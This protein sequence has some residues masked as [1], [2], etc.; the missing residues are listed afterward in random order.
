MQSWIKDLLSKQNLLHL[1][2]VG[3]FML[4]AL[5]FYYPLLG[6]KK[7][8][9]SDIQQYDGMS[10][11]LKESRQ[12]EDREIYWIDNAFVGMPTY[13]LGAQYP[14][15]VLTPLYKIIRILPRPAHILFLYLLASYCFLL[16][17]KVPWHTSLFG[18]IGFGFSTY[19]LIILQV[20]HNTKALAV[21]Y[22]PLVFSGIVLLY[23]NPKPFAFILTVLALALQIRANHYQMTYYMLL[24]ILVFVASIA[25][26]H[27]QKKT[28]KQFFIP[29]LWL[30][31]AGIFSLGLNA[32]PLLA[33]AEYAKF[34]TRG[35][36]ELKLTADGR[37][38]TEISTGLAYDYITEYSYGIFESFNIIAPRIQGGGSRE[39]IGED[40]ELYTFLLQQGVPPGQ[41][42]QIVTNIPTYWGSQP[43]LE[44]P[45][46][47]GITIFFFAIL[48]IILVRG[49]TRNALLIGALLSL[50]LSWGKN[51]PLLTDF[52]IDYFPFYNKFRA[53]SSIQVILEF[54]L[55][56]LAALGMN[57]LFSFPKEKWKKLLKIFMYPMAILVLLLLIKGS[58]S[59]QGLNDSYYREIFGTSIFEMIIDAR[60]DF[61]S[62]DVL[63]ALIYSLV[64]SVI[65]LAFVLKKIKPVVFLSLS[66][67]IVLV[68]LLSISER[69]IDR[70]LFVSQN[71][72][73]IGFQKT[74][75]DQAI[76]QD[77]TRYRVMEPQLGLTGARTANFHNSIGGYHGAKPRRLEELYNFYNENQLRHILDLL[78]IKYFLFQDSLG[79]RPSQNG[80]AIG[81]VWLVDSLNVVP[82][83]D[84][85]L[86][87]MKTLAV[88]KTAIIEQKDIKTKMPKV[89]ISDSLD[90]ISLLSAKIDRLSYAVNLSSERLAIFSEMY[91]PMGWQLE[92]DGK[93]QDIL[94]VNYILR[95]ALLPAG[96]Y[97]IDFSFEP[98]VVQR[99]TLLRGTTLILFVVLLFSWIWK[100]RRKV[101]HDR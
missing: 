17:L 77:T 45:A 63:R 84:A 13:Q 39:D 70:D 76:L 43:I 19:L 59:F 49:P 29:T 7:L 31:L 97:R 83:A 27:F 11:Q 72:Q 60:K 96:K 15:D 40:S 30:V 26:D 44:A 88:D 34:S 71:A 86:Q 53:V 4:I 16:V 79:L 92:I 51:L 62:A 24:L 80:S 61:Y 57:A 89:F 2:V 22:I 66:I 73:T 25:W 99:G 36:S 56:V 64:L 95:G 10:R 12:I 20:G 87:A 101:V 5:L 58:F 50:F 55:P 69:Y 85:A 47:I 9:Q 6:G 3:G 28:Y 52:M 94:R 98:K 81:P 93:L 38:K 37:P 68:D 100:E 67:C 33:T 48:G 78:N 54:C 35:K 46:Y 23:R 1:S 90:S 75:A 74:P 42:A 32:T 14:I 91:Y 8:F 18:A 65:I 82:N 41:A 21:G